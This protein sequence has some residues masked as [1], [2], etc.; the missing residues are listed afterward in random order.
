MSDVQKI[1]TKKKYFFRKRKQKKYKMSYSLLKVDP[2]PLVFPSTCVCSESSVSFTVY[3]NGNEIVKYQWRNQPSIEAE[4]EAKAQIDMLDPHIRANISQVFMFKSDD[5]KIEPIEGEIWPHQSHNLIAKFTPKKEGLTRTT[6]Y[7]TNIESGER[8]PVLISGKCL[9]PDAAFDVSSINTGHIALDN[10]YDYQVTLKNMGN[11]DVEFSL[12]EEETSLKFDFYHK[13]GKISVGMAMP[14]QFRLYALKVGQF[15]ETFRFRIAGAEFNTPSFAVNGRIVG[16]S[17]Q[18]DTKLINFKSVSYGFTYKQ[19]VRVTNVSDI[20]LDYRVQVLQNSNIQIREF[21]VY[22]EV[23]TIRSKSHQDITVEF[24]P[25]SIQDYATSLVM[26]NPK[27]SAPLLTIPIQATCMYP[28]LS[29]E[30]PDL[31]IGNVFI[32]HSYNFELNLINRTKLHAKYEY[33]DVNL[34][35]EYG[36]KLEIPQTSGIIEPNSTKPFAVTLTFLQLGNHSITRTIRVAGDSKNIIKF[37]F[38]ALCIGPTLEYPTTPILFGEVEVLKTHQ[39]VIEIKNTSLIEAVYKAQL[40]NP[41]T[42]FKLLKQSGRIQ[43]GATEY[44]PISVTLDDTA[45]FDATVQFLFENLTPIDITVKARG[46]GNVLVPNIPLDEINLSYIF[47]GE[48]HTTEFVINNKGRKNIDLRWSIPKPKLTPPNESFKYELTPEHFLLNAYSSQTVTITV[49]SS[50]PCDF[51]MNPSLSTTINKQKHD[52]FTPRIFGRINKVLISIEKPLLTFLHSYVPDENGKIHIPKEIKPIVLENKITNPTPMKFGITATCQE[53]FIMSPTHFEMEPDESKSFTVT[54]NPFYKENYQSETIDRK[55]IMK[56]DANPQTFYVDLKGI[57]E[58]PNVAFS[59]TV[60][61]FGTLSKSTEKTETIIMKNPHTIKVD[62]WW[63]I[64]TNQNN[65][66]MV[67]D[68]TPTK[69]QLLANSEE[70]IFFSF[71][72][73]PNNEEGPARFSGRAI[74]HVIGGPTYNI[75]LRGSSAAFDYSLSP[76]VFSFDT[77][78]ATET[79]RGEVV[80]KSMS[81][82]NFDYSVQIPKG[83]KVQEFNVS[84]MSGTLKSGSQQVFNIS[85]IPGLF[86]DYNEMFFIRIG[87]FDEER[88]SIRIKAT[89][90]RLEFELNRTQNDQIKLYNPNATPEQAASMERKFINDRLLEMYKRPSFMEKIR[91]NPYLHVPKIFNGFVISEFTFDFGEIMLGSEFQKSFNVKFVGNHIH[92]FEIFD[93]NIRGSGFSFENLKYRDLTANESFPLVIKFNSEERTTNT[94]GPAT[95]KVP[96]VINEEFGYLVY[97]TTNITAPSLTISESHINFSNTIVGEKQIVTLQMQNMNNVPV[98]YKVH[99]AEFVDAIKQK[100]NKNSSSV[101]KVSQAD[102]ILPPC[103]FQ[104]IDIIFTPTAEKL[105]QM[106]LPISVLYN[107]QQTYITLKGSGIQLKVQFDPE[108]IDFGVTTLMQA[109]KSKTIN[110]VNP[111]DFPIEVYSKNFDHDLI[112]SDLGKNQNM[113]KEGEVI[114]RTQSYESMKGVNS[115][116]FCVLVHGPPTSGKSTV[117]NELAEYMGNVPIVVLDNVWKDMQKEATSKDYIQKLHDHLKDPIYANGYIIDGICGLPSNNENEQYIAH[118]MKTKGAVD[119]FNIDPLYIIPHKELTTYE[120]IAQYVMSAIRVHYFYFIALNANEAIVSSR[121]EAIDI[122]KKQAELDKMKKELQAIFDMTEEEYAALTPEKQQE[123]DSKRENYRN[124]LMGIQE[125]IDEQKSGPGSSKKSGSSRMQTAKKARGKAASAIDP[126]SLPYLLYQYTLGSVVKTVLSMSDNYANFDK[127]LIHEEEEEKPQPSKLRRKSTT[128]NL[129]EK[130][131]RGIDLFTITDLSMRFQTVLVVSGQTNLQQQSEEIKKFV[132]EMNE[133]KTEAFRRMIE[134][135]KS[136]TEESMTTP[137]LLQTKP[138]GFFINVEENQANQ[139]RNEYIGFIKEM[140][141]KQKAEKIAELENKLAENPENEEIKAEIEKLQHPQKENVNVNEN[142]EEEEE[143]EKLEIEVPHMTPRWKIEP[144]S[145]LPIEFVYESKEV[146]TFEGEMQFGIIDAHSLPI[147]LPMSITVIHPNID[148]NMSTIFGKTTPK[149]T[150]KTEMIY[151]TE[152]KE[153]HFGSQIIVKEKGKGGKGAYKQPIHIQNVTDFPAEV[154]LTLSEIGPKSPWSIDKDRVIIP[155]AS[156]VDVNVGFTPV[157]ADTFKTALTLQIM[158][159]PDP[160]VVNFVGNGCIPIIECTDTN[161]DFEKLLVNQG[162]SCKFELKNSGRIPAFWHIKGGNILGPNFTFSA[163][164]GFISPKSST[165]VEVKYLSPKPF[166]IKKVI[167]IDIMDKTKLRTFSSLHVNFTAETFEANF[168]L[169]FPK[170]MDHVN[171]GDLKT[172]NVGNVNLGIKSKSKYPLLYKF[173]FQK[174]SLSKIIKINPMEGG[175][176]PDGKPVTV[177][178]SCQTTSAQKFEKTKGI[179]IKVIDCVS[180]SEIANVPILFSAKIVFSQFTISP[181]NKLDFGNVSA[182]IPVQNNIVI[183]NTCPFPFDFDLVSANA[184]A[185]PETPRTANPRDKKRGN[186]KPISPR[187]QKGKK[188]VNLQI[189]DFSLTPSS[190][191][192]NPNESA[193]ILAELLPS[194]GVENLSANFLIKITDAPPQFA[195]GIPFNLVAAAFTPGIDTVNYELMFPGTPMAIMADITKSDFTAF[196]PAIKLLH[197][198][199]TIIGES[200]TVDF[201][202]SNIKPVPCSIVIE[203]KGPKKPAFFVSETTFDIEPGQTKSLQI[204]FKPGEVNVFKSQ[205]VV[206]TVGGGS[207]I[208]DM[209]GTGAVPEISI[210]SNDEIVSETEP[211]KFG[212][213]LVG[214][215]KTKYLTLKNFGKVPATVA[216]SATRSADFIVN[217]ESEIQI[218]SGHHFDVPIIFKPEKVRQSKIDIDISVLLGGVT[219]KISFS[220]D[221]NK[222][223]ILFSG[224]PSDGSDLV[225]KESIIGSIQKLTFQM[226][227]VSQHVIRFTWGRLTDFTFA[228]SIGHIRPGETKN[229]LVTFNSSKPV[230]YNNINQTL[231]IQKIKLEDENCEHWDDTLKDSKFVTRRESIIMQRNHQQIAPPSEPKT[232]ARKFPGHAKSRKDNKP[233]TP[234]SFPEEEDFGGLDPEELVKVVEFHQEPPYTL[235]TKEK[236]DII[237][238]VSAAADNLKY[239]LDTNTVEFMPT[240]MYTKVNN[241][242]ILTNTCGIS[243]NYHWFTFKFTALHNSVDLSPF[244]ISPSDGILKPNESKTFTIQFLPKEVDEFSTIFRCEIPFLQTM[245][246]PEVTVTGISRRPI[247]HLGIDPSD[248]ISG[249]RRMP[250]FTEPLPNDVRV[251]EINAKKVGEK[252]IRKID[253]VNTT[254]TSYEVSWI[255]QYDSSNGGVNCETQTQLISG[256]KETHVVFSFTPKSN[257]IVESLWQFTIPSYNIKANVLVVGKVA[258]N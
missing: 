44:V 45:L 37:S 219:K 109:K 140:E 19:T 149:L 50:S 252:S 182:N 133:L 237:L 67:F 256:G 228:P 43:P 224:L 32:G 205:L 197:M 171:F 195:E 132:P 217:V 163:V 89:Y 30:T 48:K 230:T 225:F 236:H 222:E 245:A 46:V 39:R 65:Q 193:T 144:N 76:Q 59:S 184:P 100:T 159:N 15:N 152:L 42:V 150:P 220:G 218:K 129:P 164:E 198:M 108:K 124:K 114:K 229:V 183:T 26:T 18:C 137:K 208:L 153:F 138:V 53:P 254:S 38:K 176:Q 136:M 166:S 181:Q 8:I 82:F 235:V 28:K 231:T 241:E 106:M 128:K 243:F 223:D 60:V 185:E 77:A 246:M 66:K 175:V 80:L 172:N 154:S 101:F 148:R 97:I 213:V 49:L 147:K 180:G 210:E 22:P 240:M 51:E 24:I 167:Q 68:I 4:N 226:K 90:P 238:K 56:S 79:L 146:G 207:M 36:W 139:F 29:L 72:A 120:L 168:E 81:D 194:S 21:T 119:E 179:M 14:I 69:G 113:L 10:S 54:F 98:K 242:V 88:I 251:I 118:V 122:A 63:E 201:V 249:G 221:G 158:D 78:I 20:P 244:T 34:A 92:G 33:E 212:Q 247:C 115:F 151:V 12:I 200:T 239:S 87:Q 121:L 126:S 96:I 7:L 58:F 104:N 157:V 248:Y 91:K 169:V 5:L 94:L 191:T 190:G 71:F 188:P 40:A 204:S 13:A 57:I 9:A 189:D 145:S 1:V 203:I 162:R 234:V 211:V 64:E 131:P 84:P 135:P 41:S 199:N 86:K 27:Y 155:P 117:A 52:Y 143:E 23:A 160:V 216:L 192:I 107:Q 142:E 130:I 123:V 85:I 83:S 206:S 110:L 209:E 258:T 127:S 70:K 232:T 2:N 35:D 233:T 178:I 125:N 227:S 47:A 177:T 75:D 161:I 105:Y 25:V 253:I 165:F 134:P 62:Y 31:D 55:I 214:S 111:T 196:L 156:S 186:A 16:P 215:Q 112:M 6:A 174:Q 95:Y 93:K 73:A 141:E 61:N 250:E 102:G 11:T 17:F 255:Q 116:S 74:C 170:G 257:K 3:N 99:P 187:G 202:L 103:S 173:T